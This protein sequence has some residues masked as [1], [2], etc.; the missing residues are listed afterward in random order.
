MCGFS[1]GWWKVDL[2]YLLYVEV[3][4]HCNVL[5]TVDLELRTIH[6]SQYNTLQPPHLLLLGYL[7]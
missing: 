2:W 1:P 4:P 5:V 6:N 7:W 3:Q